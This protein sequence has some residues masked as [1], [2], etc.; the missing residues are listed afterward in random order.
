M[1]TI[2]QVICDIN[3]NGINVAEWCR[4]NGFNAQLVY[5]VLRGQSACKRGESHRIAVALGL[6][7]P[8]PSQLLKGE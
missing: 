3:S 4:L 8:R 5:R 7:S 2:D 1:T 6:K